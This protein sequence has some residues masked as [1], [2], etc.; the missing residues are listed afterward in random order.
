MEGTRWHS[1]QLE[2]HIHVPQR[3]VASVIPDLNLEGVKQRQQQ[4]P[5]L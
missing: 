3:I 2:R 4:S 1:L 5:A